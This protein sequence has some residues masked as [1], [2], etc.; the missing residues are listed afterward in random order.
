MRLYWVLAVLVG[1]FSFLVWHPHVQ[2]SFRVFLC[3]VVGDIAP[4]CTNHHWFDM[5]FW[6]N[7]PNMEALTDPQAKPNFRLF[8]GG[9]GSPTTTGLCKRPGEM[10]GASV[11]W[12][13]EGWKLFSLKRFKSEESVQQS[14][15]WYTYRYGAKLNS[16]WT[17]RF[18]S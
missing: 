18:Q 11:G 13:L 6:L 15:R 8:L 5:F 4:T 2:L 10:F 7:W 3:L 14:P 1:S 12:F 16:R 17:C 9:R